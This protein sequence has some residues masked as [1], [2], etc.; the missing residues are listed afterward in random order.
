[1]RAKQN[2]EFIHRFPSAGCVR[3]SPGE[4]GAVTRNG[5]LG[6]QTPSLPL[7]PLPSSPALYAG[8]NVLWSGAS[9]E[10]AVPAA[11]PRGCLCPPAPSL[12]GWVRSRK[13]LGS[14][15]ALLSNT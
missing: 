6:R 12:V 15:R 5:S 4:Q 1:M 11:S 3:P 2:K 13:G 7:S 8:H 10:S 14:V 9:L